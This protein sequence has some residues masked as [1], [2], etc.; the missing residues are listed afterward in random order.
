MKSP[1]HRRLVPTS[2]IALALAAFLGQ[3][4]SAQSTY[5][6]TPTAASTG[7]AWTTLA[8]DNW[9]TG[10]GGGYPTFAGDVA[11]VNI[12]IAGA[13]TISLGFFV[14]VGTLNL[15][16]AT[17]GSAITIASGT[18][19]NIFTFDS[20][21]PDVPAQLNLGSVAEPLNRMTSEV[22][23][24]SPFQI[25]VGGTSAAD[26]QR[27]QFDGRFTTNDQPITISG[28]FFNSGSAQT[29]FN[30]ALVGSANAVITNNS[31]SALAI[32]NVQ[33]EF[34]GKIV[35]NNRATGSNQA[36]LTIGHSGSMATASEFEINGFLSGGNT[37]NGGTVHVGNSA[38]LDFNPGQRLSQ[39]KITFNGGSLH[40]GGQTFTA[41]V[42]NMEIKDTVA[43][44]DFNSGY[45]IVT[46]AGSE[47]TRVLDVT[48]VERSQG[49][50]VFVRGNL[51]TDPTSPV[52][53]TFT[54]GN[55]AN[56][57]KGAGAASGNTMSIIPWVLANSG[58]TSAA[59]SD[60]FA[61][62][63]SN[64]VRPLSTTTE[65]LTGNLATLTVG[66]QH[67]V[68]T[69]QINLTAAANPAVTVN[70][71]RFSGGSNSVIDI[72]AG[73]TLVI[74]SGGLIFTNSSSSIGTTAGASAGTLQFGENGN[75]TEGVIWSNGTALN[76]IGASVRGAGGITKAGTG[77]LVLT[78]L[79][80][81]YTGLT[82]VGSGT[83]QVGE[84]LSFSTLGLSDEVT[85]AAGAQLSL[86]GGNM[87]VDTATLRLEQYGLF[88][89]KLFLG[90]NVNE[91]VGSLWI[92]D[93]QMDAG[94]YGA[95]GA[96]GVDFHSE[97]LTGNGVL[98]VVPEPASAVFVLMG[99]GMAL[100]RR[101]RVA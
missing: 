80:N 101:R 90:D 65:Y 88:T 12:D 99:A 10:V 4:A 71:L 79:N 31:Q 60:T 14:T 53:T 27:I 45:S 63:T 46:V 33:S 15:G 68:S 82:Y 85:I 11:N 73:K 61:T 1:L 32:N 87:I 50:S 22:V 30:G 25:N 24:S 39:N 81:D 58:N 93:E 78:G 98:E 23:L 52:A 13:Q 9:G 70:S 59:T 76:R 91:V 42:A 86:I 6:W 95:I 69:S 72:G 64:G 3:A 51:F 38:D 77:T 8:Q 44:F 28:G 48:N 55:V 16:D 29:V 47:G 43:T 20:G 17:G 74:A 54:I 40:A 97:F 96:I 57:L 35:V 92:G 37:Q 62:Y 34:F 66:A 49:A 75:P 26:A 84:G 19:N 100:V 5:T 2:A 94:K 41:A 67:N 7:Y 83:L 21:V 36:G 56:Y 18:G 89:G